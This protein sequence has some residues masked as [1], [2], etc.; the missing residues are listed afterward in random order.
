MEFCEE[1][2]REAGRRTRGEA[3]GRSRYK[4]RELRSLEVGGKGEG[5]QARD[6]RGRKSEIQGQIERRL[7]G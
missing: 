4:D 5:R 7:E 6:D 3:C 2:G 1:R